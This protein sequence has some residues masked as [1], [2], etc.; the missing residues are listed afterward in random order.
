MAKINVILFSSLS[1]H[2][3]FYFQP[4]TVTL[5]GVQLSR[6][7]E[8]I[9]KQVNIYYFPTRN[10]SQENNGNL[11]EKRKVSSVK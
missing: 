2:L 7:E 5:L 4:W 10:P 9:Y 6:V 3:P 11:K 8:H 1:D